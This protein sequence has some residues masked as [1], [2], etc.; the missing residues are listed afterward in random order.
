MGIV[1]SGGRFFLI[2]C[3]QVSEY[4][5]SLRRPGSGVFV[6]SLLAGRIFFIPM[7][8]SVAVESGP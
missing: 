7:T 6:F 2:S 1:K 5:Q 8:S 4:I 3:Q